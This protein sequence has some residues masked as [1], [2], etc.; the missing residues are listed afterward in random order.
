MP[1]LNDF[2]ASLIGNSGLIG[3]SDCQ[4]ALDYL[5]INKIDAIEKNAPFGVCSLDAN[6][7]VS[8][9]NLP[10]IPPPAP[11]DSWNGRI[12]AVV[13]QLN[14]FH[15]NQILNQPS[16]VITAVDGQQAI[17]QLE[18]LKANLTGANF[19]G[20]ISST[21]DVQFE[22]LNGNAKW[23]VDIASTPIGGTGVYETQSFLPVLFTL[24]DTLTA[25]QTY[26]LPASITPYNIYSA[27]I[28][29]ETNGEWGKVKFF[30]DYTLPSLTVT[31]SIKKGTGANKN[32][33]FY[34]ITQ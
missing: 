27:E 21:H 16:G 24:T 11:V 23:P 29:N 25:D 20:P 34:L 17:N 8:N 7:I 18:N 12:G 30:L 33:K 9:I 1:Q 32:I 10:P 22:T 28:S 6:S 31:L 19:T 15:C 14:D 2:T 26:T 3:V 4:G 13:P 5:E